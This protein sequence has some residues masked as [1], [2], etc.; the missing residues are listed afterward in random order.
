[1]TSTLDV[2][3]NQI[4]SMRSAGLAFEWLVRMTVKTKTAS[5]YTAPGPR[6]AK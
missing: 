1:M 3:F 5:G 2:A 6:K 4:P